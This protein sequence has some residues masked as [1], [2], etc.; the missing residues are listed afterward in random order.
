MNIS[1]AEIVETFIR[2]RRLS[3]AA[4]DS[5]GRKTKRS[6]YLQGFGDCAKMLLCRNDE[7][8]EEQWP[9]PA[10]S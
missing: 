1:E 9:Q 2:S 6:Q 3:L 10:P 5:Q 4:K 7:E 8:Q